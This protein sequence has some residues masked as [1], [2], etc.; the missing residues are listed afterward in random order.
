MYK[1]IGADG[2]EYGPITADIL[3][4][5]SAEGRVNGQTQV[6]PEGT[7][8]WRV[9]AEYPELAAALPAVT[10]PPGP[11]AAPSL[12]SAT[13]LVNGPGIG[14]IVSGALYALLAVFRFVVAVVGF[15]ISAGSSMGNAELDKIMAMSGTLSVVLG[16]LTLLLAGVILWGGIQMRRFR[17]YG[18]CMTAAILAMIPC[19][20]PCCVVG[21][22][23]GIWA[24]VVLSKPE[25]K[26][27]FT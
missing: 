20:V 18:L 9:L 25:V 4:K 5:W 10:L 2:K 11:A 14:L 17:S 15:G 19:T 22:P 27:Q 3:K 6:A 24:L 8:D 23:I 21:L 7:T 16:V 26:S 1:I 12:K 13:D